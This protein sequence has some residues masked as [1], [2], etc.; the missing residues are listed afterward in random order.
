MKPL[1]RMAPLLS[2]KNNIQEQTENSIVI[3]Q[4]K[5]EET[6]PLRHSVMWP[7]KPFDHIK[8]SND[9]KGVHYGL[10]HNGQ[11]LAVVSLFIENGTAQFRKLAT[12]ESEQ[13]KGYAS[14]LLYHLM[15]YVRE[16]NVSCIWCNARKDKVLFYQKFKMKKTKNEF[17]KSGLDYIIMERRFD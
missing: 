12:K 15:D 14:Q 3:Q 5:A 2:E 9:H 4:I 16:N 6:W 10:F 17:S 7:D 8:L 11:L 13:G 1:F